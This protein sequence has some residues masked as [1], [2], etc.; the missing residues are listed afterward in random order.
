MACL[1]N[2]LKFKNSKFIIH[3]NMF[4]GAN[5]LDI[6]GVLLL[7]NRIFPIQLVLY[8]HPL[9]NVIC[10]LSLRFLASET[11]AFLIRNVVSNIDL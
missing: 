5:C 11:K 1:A 8:F 7:K 4:T 3:L 6:Q 10:N 2:S 9:Q